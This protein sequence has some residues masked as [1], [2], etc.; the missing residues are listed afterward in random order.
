MKVLQINS[1]VNTTSTGRIAEEI[2]ETLQKHDHESYIAYRKAGPAGSTSNLIPIG[3]KLDYY[4]HGLK[5]RL[6]DR[7]GF[8]SKRATQ[9]LVKEIEN[10][11]P[12]I[13]ALHNLHGYYLNIEVLFN[14]LKKVQKPVVWTFHDCWPFTGHCSF[15]D[16]VGCEKWKTECHKCPLRDKYPASWFI[17]NSRNNFYKKK[18][19]FNGFENLTIVTPSKW[20]KNLVGKSF[21]SDYPVQ[22]IHNGIDLNQFKPVDTRSLELKYNLSG[23]KILLGVASVWD[24]RKGLKYFLELDRMLDDSFKIVLIGLSKEKIRE[25]PENIIGIQRTEDIHELVSF[26]S[27]A[28][29][30]IN[31]TLVDNFP[32]TNL[33]ALACGTPVITFDTGG[34]PEAVDTQ[35]GLVV[36][37]GNTKELLDATTNIFMNKSD[38]YKS[39][40]RQRAELFYD[41]EER[42]SDYV[43]I[44]E[45]MVNNS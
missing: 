30:F 17:D 38:S 40:C 10:I 18:E 3:N 4:L 28:D 14:F 34:S 8:G 22:V 6:L 35:T 20:L 5:T 21:L 24:R 15:F 32:T 11:N 7:H 44:Y 25:L 23:K 39:K 13:I 9:K 41:K 31:P 2:G 12:D 33:E 37:K 16:Y 27:A 45:N 26:Y 36:E 19:L 1:C 42:F 29:V 43:K